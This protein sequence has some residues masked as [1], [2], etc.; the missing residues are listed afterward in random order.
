MGH[1]IL[2]LPEVVARVSVWHCLSSFI[3]LFRQ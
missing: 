1:Q 3:Y 2:A